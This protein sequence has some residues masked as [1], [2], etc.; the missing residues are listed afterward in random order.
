MS[1]NILLILFPTQ[2]F[3][4]K[5]IKKI[6]DYNE[7]ID[8]NKNTY[9]D[10]DTNKK[11]KVKIINH[12]LLIEHPYFFTEFLYHKIKLIFHRAS[13]KN[14][15][16]L[17]PKE[18]KKKYVE[19]NQMNLVR[20]YIQMNKI[21]QVRFFNPIEKKLFELINSNQ[22]DLNIDL[23]VE[24]LIFPTPYFLNSTKFDKNSNISKELK[25]IRHDSFYKYQRINYDIMVIKK[26]NGKIEPEGS[27][28]SFD[29]ENRKPYESTQTEPKILKFNN[30][31]R[32]KYLAEA[33]NYVKK[34]FS[35]HYGCE[36]QTDNFIY[37]I[38][39]IESL[40]WLEHFILNKL[41]NFGKY[42]DA[43]SSKIKFGFHSILSPLTNV[44]LITP[45]DIINC[46]KNYKK[47]IA[48][49]EGFIRQ[50]IGWREYCYFTYDLFNKNLS[51]S[52]L[53]N[54]N[55]YKIPQ[56]IWNCSTQIVPIDTMLKNVESN[57]YLHHIERLMGIGN[58]L[59]LIQVSP[60]EIYKW[61]QTMFIDAY[62]VF[63]VPNVYGM[64]G[65]G[66]LESNNHMMTRPYFAS[67]NYII[68][69][70]DYKS[71]DSVEIKK[72]KY[73]WDEIFNGL[74]WAHVNKYSNVFKKIYS[75]ASAVNM[76][77]NFDSGKKKYLLNLASIYIEWIH[78]N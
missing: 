22:I 66:I 12:I 30:S 42:E 8:L 11:K 78:D 72:K 37:P 18:Y 31:K 23:L 34:N 4:I 28:W 50:I 1:K 25:T 39:R 59:I 24:N 2:L 36:L 54:S 58:F 65:Y 32:N 35:N 29:K 45:I 63:M 10:T 56:K 64:L 20:K 71:L 51:E 16:D 43:L 73:K 49:K 5:Y 60:Q 76:W 21:C 55:K 70:S 48:S 68:K 67:S 74:Y 17:I 47:N 44:G 27:Y 46:V 26:S 57:A 9:I 62:D 38:N 33:N 14:Y 40:K 69:M 7:N 75:T 15:Y 61:F 41:E 6:F 52:S 77:N 13:M 53:Y 19:Y 3:E